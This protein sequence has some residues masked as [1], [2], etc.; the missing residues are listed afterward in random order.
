M[1]NAERKYLHFLANAVADLNNRELESMWNKVKEKSQL[2]FE[3]EL[4]AEEAQT[5]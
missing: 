3:A 1:G 5:K 4:P 2:H